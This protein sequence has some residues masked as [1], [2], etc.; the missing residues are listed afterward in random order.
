VRRD[1]D[2]GGGNLGENYDDI[3]YYKYGDRDVGLGE[4]YERRRDNRGRRKL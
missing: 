2:G 4:M 1:K 3:G